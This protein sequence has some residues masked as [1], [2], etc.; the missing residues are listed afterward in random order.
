MASFVKANMPLEK[1]GSL[2]DQQAVDVAAY[3]LSHP[4]PVFNPNRSVQFPAEPAKFF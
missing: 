1:P 2:S 3:V 4:R